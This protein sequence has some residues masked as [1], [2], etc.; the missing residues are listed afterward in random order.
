MLLIYE[1][2]FYKML[3]RFMIFLIKKCVFDVQINEILLRF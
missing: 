1:R 3:V 2:D